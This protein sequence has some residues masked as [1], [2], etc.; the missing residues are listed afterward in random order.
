[1]TEGFRYEVDEGNRR[2]YRKPSMSRLK[3]SML[4]IPTMPCAIEATQLSNIVRKLGEISKYQTNV[5]RSLRG[6]G[7]ALWY[8]LQ[9]FS[10]F[11]SEIPEIIRFGIGNVPLGKN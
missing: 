11:F 1:M 8:E 6:I 2:R 4:T 5:I 3:S 7:Y 10:K 9:L